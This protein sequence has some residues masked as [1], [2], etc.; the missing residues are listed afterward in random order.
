M[1]VTNGSS[2]TNA[3]RRRL[4]R[5]PGGSAFD[6]ADPVF[7]AYDGGTVFDHADW[8]AADMATMLRRDGKARSVY[9]V[10]VLPIRSA[11]WHIDD[12]AE[13]VTAEAVS[14]CRDTLAERLPTIIDQCTTALA[15]RRAFFETTWKL[16]GGR[17]V[18]DK[19]ALRP[20]TGCEA[21]F[22]PKTGDP[23]GFRQRLSPV[24]GVFPHGD[25]KGPGH[26]SPGYAVIPPQRAFVFT[27][28]QFENPIKG[29]SDLDVAYHCFESKQKV[30]YLWFDFLQNQALPKTVVYGNDLDDAKD[31]SNDVA[32]LSSG[33]VLGLPRPADPQGKAFETLE[34]DGAGAAQFAEAVKWLD[35]QM[36]T[37]VLAGFTELATSAASGSGSYALS[38]DQSEF[39]LASRQAVADEIADSIRD[40]L[41]TPLVRHNLGPD[42]VVPKLTIGPI[43]N[44][45]AERALQLLTSLASATQLVIPRE[46]VD[47]LTLTA[48]E[49]LGLDPDTTKDNIDAEVQ[50]RAEQDE[51]KLKQQKQLLEQPIQPKTATAPAAPGKPAAGKPAPGKQQAGQG[52]VH[53]MA[54]KTPGAP[55][56]PAKP[57]TGKPGNTK[58]AP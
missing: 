48:A 8:S 18:H 26:G 27:H 33:G 32:S 14:L 19:I 36:V 24:A 47:Q 35:S 49:L 52:T 46:V 2:L 45:A 54:K 10:L 44:R 51:L 6:V 43:S 34:S 25:S 20:A 39:F 31:L 13:N 4:L 56:A 5:P 29:V 37:S 1:P 28:G 15:Y 53:P 21:G 16:D 30:S 22:D 7:G 17:V 55:A 42:A 23:R 40:G 9:Q 12:D 38:A 57:K 3:D 41:F 58:A 50:R 11:K